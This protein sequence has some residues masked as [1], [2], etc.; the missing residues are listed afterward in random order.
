MKT[1]LKLLAATAL[2][3]V[4]TGAVWNDTRQTRYELCVTCRLDATVEMVA[5]MELERRV[6][7]NTCSIWY[8]R[9]LGAHEH[10]WRPTGQSRNARGELAFSA[11]RSSLL[12]LTAPQQASALK[13]FTAEQREEFFALATS[14]DY[15]DQEQAV[16]LVQRVVPR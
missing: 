16:Q 8:E 11:K 2:L 6:H 12:C 9:E 3:V 10:V 4:L 1:T 5:G 7:P 14:S 13:A 15:D